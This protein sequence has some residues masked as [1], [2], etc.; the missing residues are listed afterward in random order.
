MDNSQIYI[1]KKRILS[2]PPLI[3]AWL[4]L[5]I[6]IAAGSFLL[7][8]TYPLGKRDY[9]YV[10]PL[11]YLE[12]ISGSFRPLVADIFYIRGI[13]EVAGEYEDRRAWVSRV[14]VNFRAAVDLDSRMTQAYFFGG[15][16]IASDEE[17][18]RRGISFL[19]KGME[20]NP[21]EWRLPYWAG[22]NYYQLGEYLKAVEYY[23][24]AS[25]LPQAPAF[26]ESNPAMLYYKAGRPDLGRAYLEGLLSSI[27]D[28]SQADWIEIKL[29][30]LKNIIELEEKARQF[31]Q[32]YGRWPQDLQE[33]AVNGLI[34][35]IPADPFGSG[36]YLDTD[37]GRVKSRFGSGTD[38]ND[39][40]G[41][42]HN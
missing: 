42:H 26:L 35:E 21:D 17:S 5:L 39:K 2:R 33:L 1:L 38:E 27:A 22:F 31:R 40:E 29:K 18:T 32:L 23:L 24:S 41:L 6:F 34:E 7:D 14:Q 20:I 13:L 28:A 10:P 9:F 15:V 37:S 16:V 4:L 30:W 25:R 11:E 3:F 12:I 36:Y 19:E 8:K